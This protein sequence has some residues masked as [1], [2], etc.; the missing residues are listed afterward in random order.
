VTNHCSGV[1]ELID[2]LTREQVVS[3]EQLRQYLEE[4]GGM[5]SL[6]AESDAA[7]GELVQDGLLTAFQA[8]QLTTGN[9][10][11]LRVGKYLLMDRLGRSDSSVYQAKKLPSGGVLAIKLLAAD[12]SVNHATVERFRREAEALARTDHPG[13]VGIKEFGESSGRLFLAMEYVD[14]QTL[15]ERVQQEGPLAPM[16][17]VRVIQEALAAMAHMHQAGL[18]HR[19]LRPGHLMVDREGR[20]RILDLGV[21]RFLED[22]AGALTRKFEAGR[23]LGSI[24]Y[25]APEQMIDSHDIDCRA[26][27]Y[28]LGATFYYLLTGKAPFNHA[29]LLRMAAGVVTRPQPVGQARPDV[30]ASLVAIV[31][32][33]MASKPE[34]R[35]RTPRE[36]AQ[37]LEAWEKQALA[38]GKDARSASPA[39]PPRTSDRESWSLIVLF[40]AAAALATLV[41]GM[42]WKGD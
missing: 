11:D 31:E 13:V 6:P 17:A 5:S 12:G 4:R 35:Y 37:A 38:V 39:V 7:L 29:A 16:A 14:G 19:D 10:G 42:L 41:V 33:M 9:A 8:Q 15:V 25:Q 40:A 30:P 26:D 23:V 34:D 28:A 2:L 20:V 22:R 27:V 32:K 24:E 21:A 1:E 18:I 3:A 36:A